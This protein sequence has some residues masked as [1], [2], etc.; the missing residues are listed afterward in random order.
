MEEINNNLENVGRFSELERELLSGRMSNSDFI[1]KVLEVDQSESSRQS[2]LEAV[3]L[4]SKPNIVDLYINSP[5]CASFYSVRSISYFHKAQIRLS[6]GEV[7]VEDDLMQALRDAEELD[8][9]GY[10]DWQDYIKAT[11]FY[12]RNDLN[13]LK[14]VAENITS[15]KSLV[16]NFVQGLEERGGPDYMLDYSKPREDNR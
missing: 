13:Q 7:E 9:E 10:K 15:N 4:L 1:E 11:I 14:E 2:A 12:L 5:E 16:R 3:V 8:D 6:L